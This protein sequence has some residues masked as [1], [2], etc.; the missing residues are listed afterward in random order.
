MEV[1]TVVLAVTRLELQV[2]QHKFEFQFSLHLRAVRI[3]DFCFAIISYVQASTRYL[4]HVDQITNFYS[5]THH[6]SNKFSTAIKA[7]AAVTHS[8]VLSAA[9]LQ[10]TTLPLN[11]LCV[12]TR[13]ACCTARKLLPV[14]AVRYLKEAAYIFG[15]L[16]LD[17]MTFY[18]LSLEFFVIC[19]FVA[20]C[21][22]RYLFALTPVLI[23]CSLG[24][25]YIL[26]HWLSVRQPSNN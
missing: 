25:T 23:L 8:A 1:V 17:R 3:T 2:R 19:T 13:P 22:S 14:R 16:T 11:H 18:R 9:V 6:F 10:I 26:I 5:P 12:S 20:V 4:I 24:Y 7:L 21:L 15:R